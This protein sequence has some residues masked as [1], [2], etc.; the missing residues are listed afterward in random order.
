[1]KLI[2]LTVSVNNFL[3][4]YTSSRGVSWN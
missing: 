3:D 4:E 1:M 2:T